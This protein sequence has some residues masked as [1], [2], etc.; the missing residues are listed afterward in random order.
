MPQTE[1]AAE[2]QLLQ[3]E[4]EW[5]E[6][7]DEVGEMPEMTGPPPSFAKNRK[8]RQSVS[9]ECFG[10]T[11]AT[12]QKKKAIPKTEQA[13]EFLRS[14]LKRIVLFMGID[15][16]QT[17]DVIDACEEFSAQAGE[18]IIKEGDKVA[19]WFY[20]LEE[21]TA[22]ASIEGKGVVKAYKESPE[23]FGELALMYSAPRAATVTATSD[24]RM[25][26]LDRTTF[27]MI[28]IASTRVKREKYEKFL[29]SVPLLEVL[30]GEEIAALAD[31]LE[32]T[33]YEEGTTVL[34]EG[35]EGD[36]FFIVEEGTITATTASGESATFE[37]ASYF[38]ELALLT[39]EPRK[40]TCVA[41]TRC[42]LI[43]ID[44]TAFSRL[45]GKAEEVLKRN[46]EKY[47]VFLEKGAAA[48]FTTD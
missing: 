27:Q 34:A 15:D 29:R 25:W 33:I 10:D 47:A 45:L 31:V 44:V 7:E 43:Q 17:N 16:D 32:P 9:A 41:T 8:Q 3:T 18:V 20:I 12:Y 30:D 35:A 37:K 21:G 36:T 24:C 6:A 22:E 13:K 11:L 19:D 46:A 38:G 5:D 1:P 23:S 39:K 2:P 14:A 26:R 42:K 48:V 40:A 28:V 4:F